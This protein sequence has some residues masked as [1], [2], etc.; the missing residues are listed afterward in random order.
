ML[1]PNPVQWL[2]YAWGGRLP[3]R[4]R[5]WVLHDVTTRTWLLRHMA[6]A[7]VLTLTAV[8]VVFIPL[9]LVVH[10]VFWLAV[11][12]TV[13]GVLVSVY[14]SMSYAW[15]SGDVRLTKYGYPAGH[16]SQERER[17]AEERDREMQEG[18]R[19]MWR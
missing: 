6:R 17:I 15:E 10:V 1:R 13:L 3:Q 12:A 19:A 8:A 9:V 4:Y 2:W 16:G 11:A 7:V 14:Y 5:E 18:Y